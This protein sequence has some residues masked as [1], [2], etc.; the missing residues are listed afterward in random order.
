M[1]RFGNRTKMQSHIHKKPLQELKA[2]GNAS[3]FMSVCVLT[4]LTV[5]LDC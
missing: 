2:E 5:F 4:L 3:Q 1:Y